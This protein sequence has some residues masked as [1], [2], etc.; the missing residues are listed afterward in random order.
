[1]LSNYKQLCGSQVGQ[2]RKFYQEVLVNKKEQSFVSDQSDFEPQLY[3]HQLS[4]LD[5]VVLY[6]LL[7]IVL[8]LNFECELLTSLFCN[9]FSDSGE[10]TVSLICKTTKPLKRQK[11][12]KIQGYC[13]KS[14]NDCL[15]VTKSLCH[16][17]D[18][19][20]VFCF[21]ANFFHLSQRKCFCLPSSSLKSSKEPSA[22]LLP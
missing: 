1:M 11:P 16:L 6:H 7:S 20:M 19:F 2:C 14:S 5:K 22:M 15:P 21:T 17:H 8:T 9:T 12:G 4:D 18:V 10:A 13:T 3:Y